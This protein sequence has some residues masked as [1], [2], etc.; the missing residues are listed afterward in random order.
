MRHLRPDTREAAE[1]GRATF[2]G[3]C[4][5]KGTDEGEHR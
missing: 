5:G 1:Q 3:G 4:G 2:G